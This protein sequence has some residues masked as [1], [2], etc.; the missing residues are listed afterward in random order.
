MAGSGTRPVPTA[1]GDA[2]PCPSSAEGNGDLSAVGTAVASG[3]I[4]PKLESAGHHT[5]L[6]RFAATL[7]ES[8]LWS[9]SRTRDRRITNTL[10][11][12]LSYPVVKGRQPFRGI[13]RRTSTAY[14]PAMPG[15][16]DGWDISRTRAAVNRRTDRCRLASRGKRQ[17]MWRAATPAPPKLELLRERKT[18]RPGRQAFR[19]V[20][21]SIGRSVNRPSC[22]SSGQVS[23]WHASVSLVGRRGACKPNDA[24]PRHSCPDVREG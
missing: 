2:Y 5:G 13:G 16:P 4:G 20:R 14:A 1:H 21:E 15:A 8:Q 11:Y 19:G 9:G 22:L 6:P 17:F 12:P 7:V 10:L 18:K 23:R 3:L 24:V